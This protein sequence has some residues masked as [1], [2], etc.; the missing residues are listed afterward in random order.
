MRTV[1][2][3]Y[4]ITLFLINLSTQ[5]EHLTLSMSSYSS[6]KIEG[7]DSF[8]H[9]VSLRELILSPGSKLTDINFLSECKKLQKLNLSLNR[10]KI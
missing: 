1:L 8:K 5:L 7:L 6:D 3:F 4:L 2:K 10:R 9:L